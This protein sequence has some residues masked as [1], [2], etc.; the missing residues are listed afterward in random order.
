MCLCPR[1]FSIYFN[2][3]ITRV[4][5]TDSIDTVRVNAILHQVTQAVSKFTSDF[6][7]RITTNTFEAVS[8]TVFQLLP[9]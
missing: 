9:T 5:S 2:I 1:L 7:I 6:C 3:E 8:D 4:S